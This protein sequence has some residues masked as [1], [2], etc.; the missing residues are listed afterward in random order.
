M[1]ALAI[2]DHGCM[3]GVVNF[4]KEAI[5]RDIKPIIGCEVYVAKRTMADR[6][7]RL[8]SEQYHLVL[9]ARNNTGYKNLMKIVS[10]GY[11]EGFYYKPRVDLSVLRKYSEGIICLSGCIAGEIQQRLLEGNYQRAKETALEYRDI[12]GEENFYLEIQ[13]HGMEEQKK[14]ILTW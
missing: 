6:D 2:T 9:L 13:D 10:T 12:F 3:F 8:D 4:Y 5:K 7:P 14:I 1:K 11:L